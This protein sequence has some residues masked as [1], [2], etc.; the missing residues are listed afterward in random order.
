MR[1]FDKNI[2]Y[3]LIIKGILCHNLL[4]INTITFAQNNYS[5]KF[6]DHLNIQNN[7]HFNVENEESILPLPS[8]LQ[9]VNPLTNYYLTSEE[10]VLGQL[11]KDIK[12]L[13]NEF[14]QIHKQL[15]DKISNTTVL[16]SGVKPTKGFIDIHGQTSTMSLP[17]NNVPPSYLR[18]RSE[19]S[20]KMA[21]IPL[22]AD[23]YY[24]TEN[25]IYPG[26]NYFTINFDLEEFKKGLISKNSIDKS[27]LATLKRSTLNQK[28]QL[29][30][31][32][33]DLNR[34]MNSVQRKI[35]EQV[36]KKENEIQ[37]SIGELNQKFAS[38]DKYSGTWDTF[39]K[40]TDPK[41]LMLEKSQVSKDKLLP[42]SKEDSVLNELRVQKQVYTERLQKI[43][44][45]VAMLNS[46]TSRIDSL[47]N[48]IYQLPENQADSLGK[49]KDE[50]VKKSRGFLS[51]LEDF[52][53]G[54]INPYFSGNTLDGI[55][56]NGIRCAFQLPDSM[57]KQDIVFG[58]TI[59]PVWN[60]S[61]SFRR[62]DYRQP[63]I[64]GVRSQIFMKGNHELALI[65][66]TGMGH[67]S[68]MNGPMQDRNKGRSVSGMEWNYYGALLRLNSEL[69][70]SYGQGGYSGNRTVEGEW[71]QT[72]HFKRLKE[73]VSVTSNAEYDLNPKFKVI[74]KIDL[75]GSEFSSIGAPFKRNNFLNSELGA[76]GNFLN[77]KVT[78]R[79]FRSVFIDNVTKVNALQNRS[80][81]TGFFASSHFKSSP[82]FTI[83]YMPVSQSS[84]T[85]GTEFFDIME[86]NNLSAQVSHALET[87][88]IHS[89][90]YLGFSKFKS[91]IQRSSGLMQESNQT[92]INNFGIHRLRK[93]NI[94][95]SL[96]W[97]MTANELD[98]GMRF[99]ANIHCL[100]Q[101]GKTDLRI[102]SS[103]RK[104]ISSGFQLHGGMGIIKK[105]SDHWLV[106][107]SI[108]FFH[109]KKIWGLESAT[110]LQTEIRV[111]RNIIN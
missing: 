36:A 96:M 22:I 25:N 32:K 91:S 34:K 39:Y 37:G 87:Q 56:L 108:N 60:N 11:N 55:P 44:S 54:M 81:S 75:K 24:T 83:S 76:Q 30:L 63:F 3:W 14:D 2:R 99:G 43:D 61:T 48:Q 47:K 31:T 66:L 73:S 72:Q 105:R 62:N 20:F 82:N 106:E 89:T 100:Y 28:E 95:H 110:F 103:Y 101:L 1:F 27:K 50:I 79:V 15:I 6:R 41:Q 9:K 111:L 40:L 70:K 51:Q 52:Q 104:N 69:V 80:A 53:I 18:V 13:T 97:R 35:D 93:L 58:R 90:N 94:N 5:D 86:F 78:A 10:V 77:R 84:Q 12:T 7:I 38:T 16:N 65:N 64:L 29:E 85:I 102:N 57:H 59:A 109:M 88:N 98:S 68:E 45:M 21:G 74:G 26:S 8:D 17:Y 49:H 71:G 23:G 107:A 33:K 46:L 67:Q 42:T 92:V 4:I 19:L